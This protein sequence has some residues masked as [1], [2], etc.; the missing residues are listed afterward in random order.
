VEDMANLGKN[1]GDWLESKPHRFT[2]AN[3]TMLTLLLGMMDS[4]PLFMVVGGI[5]LFFAGG[6]CIGHAVMLTLKNREHIHPFQCAL[7]WAPGGI[8]LILASGGIY[9]ATHHAAGTLFHVMGCV[10]FGFELA[11]LAILGAELR[12]KEHSLIHYLEVK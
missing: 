1:I 2:I 7:I 11:M 6:H 10:L 3:T 5:A 4:V 8:A 12:G 9:L